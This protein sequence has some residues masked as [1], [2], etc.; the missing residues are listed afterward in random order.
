[1]LKANRAERRP[2]KAVSASVTS[3]NAPPSGKI[4]SRLIG[5]V[6]AGNRSAMMSIAA[7]LSSS[8]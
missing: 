7:S 6:F 4:G 1:M 2:P 3:A 8:R 5:E